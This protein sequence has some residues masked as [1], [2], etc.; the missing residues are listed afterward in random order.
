MCVYT[1]A[2]GARSNISHWLMPVQQQQLYLNSASVHWKLKWK[3]EKQQ[4]INALLTNL[5]VEIKIHRFYFSSKAKT[6][7]IDQN[8][9]FEVHTEP[10]VISTRLNLVSL[11]WAVAF[12][13]VMCSFV[14]WC[15]RLEPELNTLL[16][17]LFVFLLLL[18][19][20]IELALSIRGGCSFS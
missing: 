14:I 11:S 15:F 16:C 1:Y 6:K 4:H 17:L 5:K 13:F 19:A 9:K 2:I 8:R 7:K 3:K 20:S 18:P 12:V 10:K